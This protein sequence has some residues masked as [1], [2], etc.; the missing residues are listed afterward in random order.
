MFYQLSTFLFLTSISAFA[1]TRL[2]SVNGQCMTNVYSDRGTLTLV[3]QFTEKNAS[4]ASK[5]TVENYEKIRTAVQKLNLKDL[6]LKTSEY[7]VQELFDYVSNKRISKGMQASMG[8]QVTTSD[9]ARL[10]EVVALGSQVEINR[11]SNLSTF[12]SPE[13]MKISRENCLIDAIKNARDKAEKMAKSAGAKV[14]EAQLIE[15]TSGHDSPSPMYMMA[16]M[17][18]EAGAMG[19]SVTAP[20][21]ESQAAPLTVNVLVKFSLK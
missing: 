17:A 3:S 18:T 19:K 11:V 5:K 1:S 10:G 16:D 20:R 12:V 2:I 9:I 6:E 7:N 8:L 21:V 14:G 15:E 4:I 13:K